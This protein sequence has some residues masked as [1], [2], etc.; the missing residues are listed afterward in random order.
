MGSLSAFALFAVDSRT[1]A[2]F[3]LSLYLDGFSSSINK[4][5]V[6][7]QVSLGNATLRLKLELD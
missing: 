4:S 2:T 1:E 3:V 5:V 7:H 6:H